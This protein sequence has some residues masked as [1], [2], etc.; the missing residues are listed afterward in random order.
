M[1]QI[2]R[3]PDFER[4]LAAI[5]QDSGTPVK[6]LQSEA[7]ADLEEMAVRPGKYTVAVW[8]RF[9]RWLSR[10]YQV[11]Y[12]PE[13]VE[14]LKRLNQSSALVF[15][16]NHRS[17]LDPLVLRAA[18]ESFGFPPNNVL[19]GA[20]LKVWPMSELGKRNGIVF[21]R[22]EFRDDKVYRAVLKAYLAYLIAKRENLEWYIE[23]GRTR[24]GKLRQPRYGVLSYVI[25]AYAAHPENDVTIIPT[26][27]IYDQQHEVEAISAEEMGGTKAPES[28]SWLYRFAMSQSRRLGQAHIRFGEPLTLSD[29]V[30]LTVD[31]EGNPRPRLAVP[32]VAFEVCNRINAATPVTAASLVTYALLD[33]GDRAV[34]GPEGLTVLEPLYDYIRQRGLPTTGELTV[35][36]G[37][38]RATLEQLVAEN[39]V[40]RYDGGTETV[41]YVELAHQ[42]EAAFY[43]NTIIHFFVARAITELALLQAAEDG[44]ADIPAATWKNARRLKDILK[45]EFSFPTTRKFA[46]DVAAESTMVHPGWEEGSYTPESVL[47][48]LATLPLLLAHRVIGPF[49]EAYSIL[50]EEL[51]SLD[52]AEPVD[53]DALVAR[54]LGIAQQR[55]LQK[56]LRT[57]ESISRDYFRNALELARSEGLLEPDSPDAADSAEAVDAAE[58]APTAPLA[59]RRQ[60]FA[61]ELREDVRRVDNLRR[62]AQSAGQPGLAERAPASSPFTAAPTGG[63]AATHG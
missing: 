30:S 45:N 23:G 43:R 8:D 56:Q 40:T 10:A 38:L 54:C 15:L 11:D 12:N 1:D 7:Q 34:T 20:N 32:K 46:E 55:W 39:V 2:L 28:L 57:A 58:T 62:I 3:T 24:T 13:D 26:S 16:P 4:T 25:D 37:G 14:G 17:Y 50:A 33:N 47:G 51:A 41:Y 63:E 18:L 9:C 44:A 22:R 42:H 19:G 27:I 61:T 31:E 59:A 21:I 53:E 52:P 36:Q 5:A 29:A 60:A 48:V 6:Q 49:L 35:G